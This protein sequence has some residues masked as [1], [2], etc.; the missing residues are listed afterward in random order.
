[1]VILLINVAALVFVVVAVITVSEG[2]GMSKSSSNDKD[3]DFC[4]DSEEYSECR[5]YCNR[6]RDCE[7]L[8]D[9]N[10]ALRCKKACFRV[11]TMGR[12]RAGMLTK[13]LDDRGRLLGH[14]GGRI[15]R[16]RRGG[17]RYGRGYGRYRGLI[18]S[19][20][21]LLEHCCD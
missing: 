2:R 13:V 10:C 14:S 9:A 18:L 12:C 17:S 20:V 7:D 6:N 15:G 11:E 1:M 21:R 3:F 19:I 5:E 4:D 8:T 16:H